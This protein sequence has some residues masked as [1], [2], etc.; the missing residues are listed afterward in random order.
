MMAS[1]DTKRTASMEAQEIPLKRKSTLSSPNKTY[2]SMKDITSGIN[3]IAPSKEK[4]IGSKGK[5]S[6]KLSRMNTN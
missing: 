3:P 5:S 4:E 1:R 6:K 2:Q